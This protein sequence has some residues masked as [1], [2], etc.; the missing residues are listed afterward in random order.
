MKKLLL[1]LV[2]IA[3]WACSDDKVSGI[4]TVETENAFLIRVVRGD[5]LPASHVVARVRAVDFVRN[6]ESDSAEEFFAE[7][8]ADSLGYIR[9]NGFAVDSVTIE[10]INEGEGVFKKLLARDV[11]DGDSVQFVLEK[12]GSLHGKVYLPEGVDYAWV[13]V[14]GTDRLVKTD[15]NGFYELDSLPPFDYDL[16]V[17]VGDSVVTNAATVGAGEES[18]ANVYT[19]EPDSV[20]VLDF[21]SDNETFFINDLGISVSGYMIVTD[22]SVKTIPSINENF[23]KFI[24]D[25]GAGRE[26]KVLHWKT[27]AS[28]GLWSFFGTWV[29]KEKSPCNLSAM[30]SVVFYA[31][32]TGIYS[33]IFESLGKSNLEG[34]TL[35][36]D[37]LKS[38]DEW[39]RVCIKPS[40]FKPRDDMYGNFGW[41]AVSEA[42][43]TITVAA[44]D[45][46]ELW[47]DDITLYGVKPSDFATK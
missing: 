3:L 41:D 2:L 45:S 17:I 38:N 5:S 13:Q 11:R 12:T 18:F 26:G 23:A 32:G 7:Y 47:I 28:P 35:A 9:L 22:T 8:V 40:N 44:Y 25:A 42:V 19:F 31:R 15:S 6:A 34:K 37:T 46:T 10:I 24:D 27:S 39:K 20:K 33:I 16:R 1:L 4:S 21:E 30:D 29:C 36:N 43:T 14:Y